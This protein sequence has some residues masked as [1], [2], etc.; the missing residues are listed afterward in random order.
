MNYDILDACTPSPG[1]TQHVCD[2]HLGFPA[3]AGAPS[4]RCSSPTV[5]SISATSV[6]TAQPTPATSGAAT[7]GTPTPQ[8]KTGGALRIGQVGDLGNLDGHFYNTPQFYTIYT[9]YPTG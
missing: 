5:Q 2:R 6:P 8:V 9:A 7:A 4:T 1:G 3:V